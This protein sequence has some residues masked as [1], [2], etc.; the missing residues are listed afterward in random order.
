MTPKSKYNCT[1]LMVAVVLAVLLAVSLVTYAWPLLKY[2]GHN[3]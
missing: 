2:G 1:D 3:G